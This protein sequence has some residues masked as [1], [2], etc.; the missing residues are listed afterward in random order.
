LL[1]ID[2]PLLTPNPI[3]DSVLNKWRDVLNCTELVDREWATQYI[4]DLYHFH[5]LKQPK[6]I[7]FSSPQAGQYYRSFAANMAGDSP[8]LMK[9]KLAQYEKRSPLLVSSPDWVEAKMVME[10]EGVVNLGEDLKKTIIE[11]PITKTQQLVNKKLEERFVGYKAQYLEDDFWHGEITRVWWGPFMFRWGISEL[12]IATWMDFVREAYGIHYESEFW[13]IL[14]GLLKRLGFWWSFQNFCL[15]IE[16]PILVKRDLLNRLH[17]TNGS[18]IRF[19]NGSIHYALNGVLVPSKVIMHPEQIT[20]ADIDA[21][22]NAEVRRE[23]IEHY[24]LDRYLFHIGAVLI[25][26]VSY[27]NSLNTQNEE[28]K[29][30]FGVQGG[31]LYR[32]KLNGERVFVVLKNSTPEPDGTIKEYIL[33]VPSEMKTVRQAVAWTFGMQEGD[34]APVKET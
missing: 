18:A 25:D 9:A 1:P 11:K 3:R 12:R 10:K 26:R 4:D 13:V 21:I 24:G 6:I 17:C 34:Y 2:K 16:R 31:R 33:R 28:T 30:L 23:L 27:S 8:A 22:R 7:W 19:S 15:A 32:T 29:P 20:T 5:E 14:E